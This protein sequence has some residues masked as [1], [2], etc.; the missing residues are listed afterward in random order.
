MLVNTHEIYKPSL[1]T[2]AY[3]DENKSVVLLGGT[4]Q[5]KEK[6]I[7]LKVCLH[8]PWSCEIGLQR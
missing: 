8:F 5:L 4:Q 3:I 1:A 2:N 7:D 6:Q